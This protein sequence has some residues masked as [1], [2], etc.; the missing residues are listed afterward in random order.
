M[1]KVCVT[2]FWRG[3]VESILETGFT[4]PKP[5]RSAA[6]EQEKRRLAKGGRC[7]GEWTAG[8]I[9]RWHGRF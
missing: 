3:V 7:A 8:G 2:G 5:C 6:L 9:G 4:V 1:W